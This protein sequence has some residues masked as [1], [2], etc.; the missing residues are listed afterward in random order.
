VE[1]VIG[2]SHESV[3]NFLLKST[4]NDGSKDREKATRQQEQTIWGARAGNKA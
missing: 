1:P 3:Y 4:F 2:N